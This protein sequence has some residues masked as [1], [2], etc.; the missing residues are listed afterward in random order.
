MSVNVFQIVTERILE[1]L[2]QGVVPWEKPW[3]G[4]RNGA[5]SRATGKPYSIL[6]QLLLR[7]SGEYLTFKQAQEAGGTVRK[8]E[9]PRIVVFWKPLPVTEKDKEGKTVTKI[10]PMLRYYHVFHIRQCDGVE[11]RF[12]PEDLT[13]ADPIAA[14]ESILSEYSARSGCRILNE[15]QDRAYYSPSSD[16]IHLPL[17]EQFPKVE[18]YYSTAFHEAIHST[19]HEK[20]LNRLSKTAC[21]GSEDYSKE[22]LVAEIGAAT[23]M[24]ELGIETRGSFRNS[25]AYIQSWL[26]ALRND[27]RLIVSAASKA[28]KAVR[29]LLNLEAQID[30]ASV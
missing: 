12:A 2:E 14:A 27:S 19:G 11:P 17:R 25:T 18:E 5:Y 16:E 13:S 28:E 10:I 21:F 23:A 7:E 20:R 1:E 29:L 6:N 3:T 22:E 8:G 30:G 15:P 24:H 9:K 4:V 26:R